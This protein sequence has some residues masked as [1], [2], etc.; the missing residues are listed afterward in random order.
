MTPHARFLVLLSGLLFFASQTNLIWHL[1]PLRPSIFTLQ[2]SFTAESFW[3]VIEQWGKPGITIYR[4]HFVFDNIHPFIYGVFGY[5]TIAKT[6]LFTGTPPVVRRLA[7]LALPIAG[8]C[9]LLE[10]AAHSHLLALPHGTDSPII[11]LSAVCS[12]IKWGLATAFALAFFVRLAQRRWVH[13]S[14][15]RNR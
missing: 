7:L 9:D 8:L 3:Q 15:F 11:P 6:P 1:A 5:L 2:L 4:A 13:I 14:I 12:S 10:N